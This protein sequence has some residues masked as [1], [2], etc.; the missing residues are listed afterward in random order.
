LDAC[1]GVTTKPTGEGEDFRLVMLLF[2]NL[3]HR[4][5]LRVMKGVETNVVMLTVNPFTL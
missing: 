3:K 5:Y 2:T 1:G 4:T